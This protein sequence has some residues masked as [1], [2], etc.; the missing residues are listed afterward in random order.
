MLLKWQRGQSALN[1]GLTE[2]GPLISRKASTEPVRRREQLLRLRAIS[3]ALTLLRLIS[4]RVTD[5][6]ASV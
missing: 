2:G 3:I 6:M 1:T 5:D 4:K